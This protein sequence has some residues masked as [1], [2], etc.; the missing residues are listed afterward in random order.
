LALLFQAHL[1]FAKDCT[2]GEGQDECVR[3]YR[4]NDYEIPGELGNYIPTCAGNWFKFNNFDSLSANGN[5]FLGTYCHVYSDI[6]C[7]N[8]L[9]DTGNVVSS[10]RKCVNVPGAQS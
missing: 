8:Q 2:A 9:A 3:Y 7:Q 4:G 10:G 5:N 6:N 1:A